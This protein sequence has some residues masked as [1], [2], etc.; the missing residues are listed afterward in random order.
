MKGQPQL[1][2]MDRVLVYHTGAALLAVGS[3][4]VISSF[5]ALGFTGTFLGRNL[6][7]FKPMLMEERTVEG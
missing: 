6:H 4:F 3:L 1:E 2:M 5:L 7:C